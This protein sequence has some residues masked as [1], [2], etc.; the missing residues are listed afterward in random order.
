[1]TS[2]QKSNFIEISVHKKKWKVS[3]VIENYE[4]SKAAA[5]IVIKDT[6]KLLGSC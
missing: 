3:S 2:L 6:K 1:M 5:D 4:K